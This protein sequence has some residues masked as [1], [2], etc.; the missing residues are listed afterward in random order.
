MQQ[1]HIEKNTTCVGT[2]NFAK[3]TD[4]THLKSDVDKLNTVKL[5]NTM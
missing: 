5:K 4:L 2:S 3:K 1:K